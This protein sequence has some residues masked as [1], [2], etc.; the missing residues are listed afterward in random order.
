MK[1]LCALLLCLTIGGCDLN[2]LT[3]LTSAPSARFEIVQVRQADPGTDIFCGVDT[4]GLGDGSYAGLA[5]DVLVIGHRVRG[6]DNRC[7]VDVLRRNN[8]YVGFDLSELGQGVPAGSS[9]EITSALLAYRIGPAPDANGGSIGCRTSTRGL[10]MLDNVFWL[11]RN[12]FFPE[13]TPDLSNPPSSTRIGTLRIEDREVRLNEWL[14]VNPP[15]EFAGRSPGQATMQLDTRAVT[16]LQTMVNGNSSGL[17]RFGLYFIGTNGG[18][19]SANQV[20]I[21]HIENI[22]L[23]VFYRDVP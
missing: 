17:R 7:R 22:R 13:R 19:T 14:A 20:C 10:G 5:A 21:D 12:P 2:G 15:V 6:A 18:T 3:S 8:G 4:T 1:K 23:T 16:A 11:P 9:R